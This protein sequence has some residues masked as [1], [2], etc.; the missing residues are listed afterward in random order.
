MQQQQ[1]DQRAMNNDITAS[2]KAGRTIHKLE[3]QLLAQQPNLVKIR[4][5]DSLGADSLADVK[6]KQLRFDLLFSFLWIQLK[7]NYRCLFKQN[8]IVVYKQERAGIGNIASAAVTE[9]RASAFW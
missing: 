3:Q 9:T 2:S 8:C 4:Q 5:L 7:L 1:T 6:S